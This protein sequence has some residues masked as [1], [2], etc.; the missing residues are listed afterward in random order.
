MAGAIMLV[1]ASGCVSL[2]VY[3]CCCRGKCCKGGA[4]KSDHDHV[5]LLSSM[6]ED[7]PSRSVVDEDDSGVPK[8]LA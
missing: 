7:M 5:P 1:L 3:C 4:A 2:I 8:S 6:D